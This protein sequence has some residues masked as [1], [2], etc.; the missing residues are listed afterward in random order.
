M[1]SRTGSRRSKTLLTP[2]TTWLTISAVSWAGPLPGWPP[3]HS[4]LTQHYVHHQVPNARETV[5]P[6]QSSAPLIA[7]VQTSAKRASLSRRL[8]GKTINLTVYSNDTIGI[9]KSKVQDKVGILPDQQ[10]IAFGGIR[11]EDKLTLS[12][13]NVQ[14]ES[15]IYLSLTLRG[16]GCGCGSI[17]MKP[18]Q[19]LPDPAVQVGRTPGVDSYAICQEDLAGDC[20]ACAANDTGA[21]TLVPHQRAMKSPP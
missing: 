10:A 18:I 15:V 4:D 21:P 5:P 17:R 13:C 11:R 3:K 20:D 1:S 12:E 19:R 14:E 16:C 8:T 2:F 7:H 9:V 6:S